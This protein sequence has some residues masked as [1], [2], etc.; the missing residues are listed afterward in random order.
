MATN[1]PK[2]QVSPSEPRLKGGLT[3]RPPRGGGELTVVERTQDIPVFSNEHDEHLYWETH[4]LADSIFDQMGPEDDGILPPVQPRT[5]PIP[6]RFSP[7]VITRLKVLAAHRN[8][9]YQT[10][11]KDFVTERLYEEEKRQGIRS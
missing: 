6:I 3:I 4:R 8:Q 2:I 10:L 1:R 7:D 11:L 9:G 5:T